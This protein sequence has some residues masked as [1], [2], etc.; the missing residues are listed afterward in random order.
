MTTL[1][2]DTEAGLAAST[3]L[4][5]GSQKIAELATRLDSALR[6]FDWTGTDAERT[7][8]TWQQ[9]EKPTLD[10]TVTQLA[11]MA[12][13]IRQEA[14]A[15][16][17]VSGDGTTAGGAAGATTSQPQGFL[18]KV[19]QFITDR[20]S[21]V[22]DGVVRTLGH[23][24]DFLGKV[25]DVLTGREDHSVSE[26]AASALLAMGAGVG[27]AVNA[28][29]GKD[30][31]WFGEGAGVA[32]VPTTVA[33]DAAQGGLYSPALARPTDLPSLM[34]SVTDS[35]QVGKDPGNGCGDVRITRVDNGNGPA[36]VVSIPGT[37][38]WSPTAGSEPR[39]LSANLQLVAGNPTAAAESVRAA[40]DA[41]GIP[42]GSPVMLVGHSQ[43]GIIA[44]Q[45][46]SDPA[47]VERYGITNVMTYGAPIDHMQL[48][49][50]VEALQ[51]QHR[52][53]VVPRLDLGGVDVNGVNSNTHVT[54]VTLASP[55]GV[56][57]V[58][59]NHDHTEYINSVREAM[60][61]DSDA[62]RILRDYQSTLSPFLV[63]PTGT[64]T[65][66]D[67]PVS[68]RP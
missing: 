50:G 43:G 61:G 63:T 31:H 14:Q 3:E 1:G 23:T 10:T 11:S 48:A 22:Y 49:P 47:F 62:A 45:L 15:Q 57:G 35:Y 39:D 27:T 42:P 5:Q 8:D 29:T 30:E 40:L 25:G 34:Q 2:M 32:G 46:A 26:I 28:V 24:G 68:R 9:S 51:V 44:G 7:L 36:Y 33:N 6:S 64:A 12:L 4:D 58:V 55:G 53:D 38:T 60:A 41:A 13:L 52:F 21:A 66:I 56:F 65:A 59:T 54:G 37:E 20:I 17:T 19:G 67:V 16:D 18:G